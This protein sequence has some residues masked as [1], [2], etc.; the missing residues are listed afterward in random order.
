MNTC[1]H[2]AADRI[3]ELQQQ[4]QVLKKRQGCKHKVLRQESKNRKSPQDA[5]KTWRQQKKV[6]YSGRTTS[7]QATPAEIR[8]QR[9]QNDFFDKAFLSVESA[10]RWLLLYKFI[11]KPLSCDACGKKF[12]YEVFGC[13]ERGPHWCCKCGAR[14]P[15]LSKSLFSGLKI[16]ALLLAKLVRMYVTVDLTTQCK[17][18]DLV[19][20]CGCSKGQALNFLAVMREAEAH[21][22]AAWACRVRLKGDIEVDATAFGKFYISTRASAFQEE[23]QNIQQKRREAGKPAAKAFVVTLQVLG[24]MERTGKTLL[25]LSDPRVPCPEQDSA[26]KKKHPKTLLSSCMQILA[27]RFLIHV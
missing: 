15:Y 27:F 10:V 2:P 26:A 5:R 22:G 18:T 6:L 13:Q 1:S 17:V 4:V 16:C 12:F 8:R 24:A 14:V 7:R 20:H 23:I 21:A 19:S 9:P 11:C 3:R 25:H